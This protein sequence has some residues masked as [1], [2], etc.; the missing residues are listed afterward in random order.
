MVDDLSAKI[1]YAKICKAHGLLDA[2][3]RADL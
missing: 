2:R 3:L 1:N